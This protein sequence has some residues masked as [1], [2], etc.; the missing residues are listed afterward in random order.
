MFQSS[1]RVFHLARFPLL[2]RDAEVLHE[3]SEWS[4]L[5]K[6][7]RALDLVHCRDPLALLVVYEVYRRRH[8]ASIIWLAVNGGVHRV[9]HSWMLTEPAGKFAH[10]SAIGVV[11]MLLLAKQFD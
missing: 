2:L 8:V 7:D 10:T 5:R 1:D 11:E 9:Q 3:K 4:L 6:L